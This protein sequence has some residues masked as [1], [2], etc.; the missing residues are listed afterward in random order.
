M[1]LHAFCGAKTSDPQVQAAASSFGPKPRC[2]S[3]W[4]GVG[5]T[6][7]IA[8]WTISRDRRNCTRTSE[9][10]R[11]HDYDAHN[12]RSSWKVTSR[13]ANFHS[14]ACSQR[15]ARLIPQRAQLLEGVHPLQ[16]VWL[17]SGRAL[18]DDSTSLL[19][20]NSSYWADQRSQE[21]EALL[22]EELVWLTARA[23]LLHAQAP[24]S[25]WW[26]PAV[27]SM[28]EKCASWL[29]CTPR[30]CSRSTKSRVAPTTLLR[31]SRTRSAEVGHRRRKRCSSSC[32]KLCSTSC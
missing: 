23:G 31:K 13:P 6:I 1:N 22:A 19:H 3:P 18:H 11:I 29:S 8:A 15:P 28:V 7:Q 32:R 4:R 17:Q 12:T 2:R 5:S 10:V 26:Q 16:L 27:L 25:R 9:K 14:L 30:P 20:T 24:R 21:P